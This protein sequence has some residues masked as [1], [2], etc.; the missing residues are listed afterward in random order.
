MI[1]AMMMKKKGRTKTRDLGRRRPMTR[2]P[3]S[4]QR[5]K[6]TPRKASWWK[7]KNG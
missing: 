3:S 1:E 5:R 6:G 2:R 4:F 7:N